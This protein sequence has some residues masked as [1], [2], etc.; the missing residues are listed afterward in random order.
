MRTLA[1]IL[2][3]ALLSIGCSQEQ[4]TAEVGLV[5]P[6]Q[7]LSEP[8]ANALV[9]DVRTPEE[10]GGGHVPGAINVPHTEVAERLEEL[11]DDR[12]RPVVVYCERGGR[13]AQAEAALLA[14]GFTDVRHLEG[15]MSDWRAKG[16]PLEQ[17]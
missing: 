2:I 17:L 4:T 7:L 10:Y 1:L 12:S 16:R 15:D 14:G 9:L 3:M 11:G 13:A 8:P 5:T 6:E